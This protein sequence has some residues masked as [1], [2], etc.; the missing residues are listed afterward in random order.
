MTKGRVLCH[1]SMITMAHRTETRSPEPSGLSLC[2]PRIPFLGVSEKGLLALFFLSSCLH[3]NSGLKRL[4]VWIF[5]FSIHLFCYVFIVSIT[6]TINTTFFF[7]LFF[8][9]SYPR[10]YCCTP[11]VFPQGHKVWLS[12]VKI[13]EAFAICSV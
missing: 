5:F 11:F 9:R 12:R 10:Y 2:A 8:C 13:S 6:I 4:F 7:L 3:L 1:S